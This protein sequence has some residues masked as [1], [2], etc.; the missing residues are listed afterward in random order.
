MHHPRAVDP[1]AH[2]HPSMFRD[3]MLMD[4]QPI[5]EAEPWY[6][7]G[8]WP[9]LVVLLCCSGLIA[10]GLYD[11]LRTVAGYWRGW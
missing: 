11:V 10:W 9:M 6:G 1:D 4:L 7:S 8:N 2:G 5:L 3:V